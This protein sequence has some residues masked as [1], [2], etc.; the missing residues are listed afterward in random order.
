MNKLEST[1]K[2]P[3]QKKNATVENISHNLPVQNASKL[4][5]VL[6]DWRVVRVIVAAFAPSLADIS[7]PWVKKQISM[8]K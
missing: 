6:M 2:I 3:A 5:S 7:V 1:S 4:A 8:D